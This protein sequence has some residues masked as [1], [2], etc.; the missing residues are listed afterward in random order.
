MEGPVDTL[1]YACVYRSPNSTNENNQKLIDNI[2]EA[3][4][5]YNEIIL[6]DDFNYPEINWDT[7]S[8]SASRSQG[9]IDL[10]QD[11]GLYQLITEPTRYRSGQEP[12]L[13]DLI[14]TSDDNL[15]SNIDLK[16]P[17]GKSDHVVIEFSVENQHVTKERK[18]N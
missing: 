18:L 6:I 10:V 1:L 14:M 13:L 3:K 17:L 9:F 11:L 7:E 12:S 16:A 15:I 8:S 4:Y 2:V 5:N